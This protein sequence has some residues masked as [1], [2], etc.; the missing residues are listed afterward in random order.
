MPMERHEW[1]GDMQIPSRKHK[2]MTTQGSILAKHFACLHV[3]WLYFMNVQ[4]EEKNKKGLEKHFQI[5]LV[6]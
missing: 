4:I 5:S 2:L 3:E 6:Y 1:N